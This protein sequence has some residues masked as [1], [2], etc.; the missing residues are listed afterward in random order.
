MRLPLEQIASGFRTDQCALQRALDEGVV[1]LDTA[2]TLSLMLAQAL[3]RFVSDEFENMFGSEASFLGSQ[4]VYSEAI[5]FSR[6]N[7]ALAGWS[8]LGPSDLGIATGGRELFQVECLEQLQ[9]AGVTE[10]SDEISDYGFVIR[11]KNLSEIQALADAYMLGDA[12]VQQAV[13]DHL[14]VGRH[15]RGGTGT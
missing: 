6:D 12:R 7:I 10:C 15:S 11:K 13:R 14:L 9:G 2:G 1:Q 8:L 3:S 4:L 5:S